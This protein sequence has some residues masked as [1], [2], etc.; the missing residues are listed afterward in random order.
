MKDILVESMGLVTARDDEHTGG[1]NECS[2]NK[3][4]LSVGSSEC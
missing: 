3:A 1:A 2:M 4:A